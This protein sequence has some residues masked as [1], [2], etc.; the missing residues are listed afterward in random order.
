MALRI[1]VKDASMNLASETGLE[2]LRL[3]LYGR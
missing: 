1:G 3:A 2:L